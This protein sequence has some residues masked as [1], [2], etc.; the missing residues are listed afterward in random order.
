M[1]KIKI[2]LPRAFTYHRYGVLW[3]KFF[4]NLN[5]KIV[6]S[7]ETN[8]EILDLGINNTIDECCLSYK[9]YLGH[10]LYLKDKCDYILVSR[11]CDYGTK[12]KVCTRFTGTYDN[13][14]YLVP[15]TEI[16]SYNIDHTRHHYE[17]CEFLKMGFKLTKNP[18]KIIYSY[19]IAKQKQKEYDIEKENEEKNKL[20]KLNKKILIL[21]HF[22]NLKDKFI[23]SYIINYLEKANITPLFSNNLD[24]KLSASFSEYFS[25]TIYWKYS[26]EMIGALYYYR[27]QIDGVI[28]IS[29]Y[30]CGIDSL[31]NNLAIAKNK[32]L[33]ILNLVIDENISDVS[34]ETKLESFIDIVKGAN[35]E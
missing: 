34:L 32:Q 15:E 29:T 24:K 14:K 4:E 12:D 25:E 22:Y 16:L 19:L 17:F 20:L 27:H 5:C 31:V 6:L 1:K 3:K 28:F 30:P 23:S 10:V 11:I 26:K 2:G 9:I 21:S 33:P 13:I 35:H 7:P 18:F 8:R